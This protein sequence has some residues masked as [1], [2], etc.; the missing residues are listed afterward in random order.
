LTKVSSEDPSF[1]TLDEETKQLVVVLAQLK[2]DRQAIYDYYETKEYLS[3]KYAKVKQLH[4]ALLKS[5]DDFSNIDGKVYDQI[6]EVTKKVTDLELKRMK[7]EGLEISY[8]KKLF[9][10]ACR[11]LVNY[12]LDYDVTTMKKMDTQKVST[13]VDN[14]SKTFNDYQAKAADKS[15]LKK[16]FD[17]ENSTDLSW[18]NSAAKDYVAQSRTLL[19]LLTDNEKYKDVMHTW[20]FHNGIIISDGQPEKL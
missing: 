1:G 15:L 11:E 4:T 19:L 20:D 9:I 8:T 3:D 5:Y 17:D 16:E 13:M 7:D 12:T 10:G 18:F 2:K 14:I 6:T